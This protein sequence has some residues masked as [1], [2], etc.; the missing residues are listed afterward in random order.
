MRMWVW[1]LA[2]F[3]GLRIWHCPGLWYRLGSGVAVA[4]CDI[5]RQLQLWFNPKPGNFHILRVRP[6][7]DNKKAYFTTCL[8][9]L[10]LVCPLDNLKYVALIILQWNSA[11]L[12]SLPQRQQS[13]WSFRSTVQ[14]TSLLGSKFPRNIT[15]HSRV[16]IYHVLCDQPYTVPPPVSLV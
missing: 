16:K 14:V 11:S 1:S 6:Q 12:Y 10:F 9:V 13:E 3:S 8:Y 15:S 2:S 4:G 5:G 7:K